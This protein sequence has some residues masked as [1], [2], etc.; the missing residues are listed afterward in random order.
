MIIDLPGYVGIDPMTSQLCFLN[1]REDV[2][3]T[4]SVSMSLL[5]K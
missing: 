1:S 5:R 3:A 2:G 4:L